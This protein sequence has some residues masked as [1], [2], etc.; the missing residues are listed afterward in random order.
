MDQQTVQEAG[1]ETLAVDALNAVIGDDPR[2]ART[3][4]AGGSFRDLALIAAWAEELVRLSRQATA[5]YESRERSA[6]REASRPV[7]PDDRRE[8]EDVLMNHLRARKTLGD[9]WTDLRDVV[10]LAAP[11]TNAG[12]KEIQDWAAGRLQS[13]I[14]F[15][16]APCRPMTATR[17]STGSCPSRGR[18]TRRPSPPADGTEAGGS[19]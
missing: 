19:T 18:P 9:G 5:D 3:V 2:A 16:P 10:L 8:L 13:W 17:A 4:L 7:T 14:S 1:T 12:T 11:H 6:W 15:V